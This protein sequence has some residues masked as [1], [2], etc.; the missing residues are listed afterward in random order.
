MTS[1]KVIIPTW[2]KLVYHI[3]S[4]LRHILTYP[5]SGCILKSMYYCLMGALSSLRY[6][7][8][9]HFRIGSILSFVK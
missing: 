2:R 9:V 4:T 3:S 5:R 8:M 6:K 7:I 1:K